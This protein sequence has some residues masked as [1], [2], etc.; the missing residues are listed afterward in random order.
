MIKKLWHRY[1]QWRLNNLYQKKEPIV[2]ALS[3]AIMRGDEAHESF[4]RHQLNQLNQQIAK[5]DRS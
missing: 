5:L 3:I 1:K 2:L 4:F